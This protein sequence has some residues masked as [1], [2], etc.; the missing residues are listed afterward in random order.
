MLQIVDRNFGKLIL[1][2]MVALVVGW[3]AG[4]TVLG[5]VGLLG[6]LVLV[7]LH[8]AIGA[9]DEA[10]FR[11]ERRAFEAPTLRAI[12]HL[13]PERR[14][15][16]YKRDLVISQPQPVVPSRAAI[17]EQSDIVIPAVNTQGASFPVQ[18]YPKVPFSTLLIAIL[19]LVVIIGAWVVPMILT[20]DHR[21]EWAGGPSRN[22]ANWNIWDGCP[23]PTR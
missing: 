8:F 3:A 17:Y 9:M 21:A 23:T 22:C 6:L 4:V 13:R 11:R 10:K 7:V 20:W 1:L 5:A 16:G 12:A 15:L 2:V 19:G 14:L 18:G